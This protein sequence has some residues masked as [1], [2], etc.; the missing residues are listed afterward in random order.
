M[1][2]SARRLQEEE[3]SAK[4]LADFRDFDVLAKFDASLNKGGDARE[5]LLAKIGAVEH[6][7][8]RG[9]LKEK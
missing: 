7:Q 2:F 5:I 3:K 4:R 9:D 8:D 1:D 6:L